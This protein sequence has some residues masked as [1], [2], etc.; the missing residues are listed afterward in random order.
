MK[1]TELNLQFDAAENYLYKSNT[2][3]LLKFRGMFI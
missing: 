2:S 1:H 3:K